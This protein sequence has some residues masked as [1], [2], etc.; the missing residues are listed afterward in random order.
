VKLGSNPFPYDMTKWESKALSQRSSWVWRYIVI[1]KGTDKKLGTAKCLLCN[2]TFELSGS[3]TNAVKEGGHFALNHKEVWKHERDSKPSSEGS[4]AGGY[5]QSTLPKYK[6]YEKN[7]LV[8]C[9][10]AVV[11]NIVLRSL[12]FEI[13][14]QDSHRHMVN[15]LSEQKY[16]GCS[17]D[18]IREQ[19]DSMHE[20]ITDDMKAEILSKRLPQRLIMA[21]DAWEAA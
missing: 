16:R 12:P 8:E 5:K 14:R 2:Q 6:V 1:K 20:N 4:A 10:R 3:T 18:T 21:I 9:H 17:T 19:I 7:K 13:V 15:T 11:A